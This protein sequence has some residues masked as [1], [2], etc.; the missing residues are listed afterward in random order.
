MIKEYQL[1]AFEVFVSCYVSYIYLLYMW[2]QYNMSMEFVNEFS[3]D[4]ILRANW[5]KMA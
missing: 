4:T 2:Y 1:Y 3:R 5:G